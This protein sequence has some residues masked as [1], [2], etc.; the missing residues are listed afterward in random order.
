MK[1]LKL[2]TLLLFTLPALGQGV[3]RHNTALTRA[4]GTIAANVVPYAK[5][6]ICVAGTFCGTLQQVYSDIA[7]TQ[8][9]PQPVT[10][11]ASGNYSY[12]Y[13]PGCIDEQITSPNLGKITT[14][15]VCQFAAGTVT[16]LV[17]GTNISLS[18]TN[19]LGTVTIS[20]S[21]SGTCGPGVANYL[22]LSTVGGCAISLADF[23]VTNAGRFTFPASTDISG[24]ESSISTTGN[25]SLSAG[26]QFS[27][28]T[29]H[30]A[31]ISSGGGISISN[32]DNVTG[33][34]I[35]N[36]GTQPIILTSGAGENFL[37]TG[38]FLVDA[39]VSADF[40]GT[41]QFKLPVQAGYSTAAA[42]EIGYDSTNL[43]WH[44]QMAGGDYFMALF[45][46]GSPPTNGQCAS[47]NKVSNWW[48]L[49]GVSCGS[50]GSGFPIVIGSTT[51]AASSTNTS[52]SGLTLVAPA[53]GTPASVVLTN[54]TG[55]PLST[56]VTGTLQAAQEPAHTGDATNTAGSLAMTV[57][58]I[59]G[60]ALSGLATGLLK[61]TTTT[62][63]PSIATAGTDYV[64]PSGNITG[65]AGNLSGTPALPNGTTAT[66]QTFGDNTTKLATD[67]FVIANAG[68]GT[69]SGQTTGF[70][71]LAG[72]STS[73]TSTSPI[74]YGVT[75]ANT[76]TSSKPIAINA[77]GNGA[78][79]VE[80][81][82]PSGVASSDLI[83]PDSTAHRFRMN[84]NNGGAF[85]V[86]ELV[87]SGTIAVATGAI[88]SAT[89]ATTTT[90]VSGILST[91]A[92]AWNANGSLKAVT[93]Y[94][95]STSGGLTLSIYPTSGNLVVD[96]CNWTSGSITPG[97]VT[98]NYQV[99]R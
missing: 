37:V 54:A 52:L 97:A 45:P 92:V 24:S 40:S 44:V 21:G 29:T 28:A 96:N 7:L 89:C 20:S 39:S 69:V 22:L 65:T 78:A 41:S 71:G 15:N 51:I 42:G 5:I 53:L 88:S 23:G 64:V 76:V 55:L 25:I 73:I 85:S 67:A 11:D 61:N 68:S 95:P 4:S 59:N 2:A 9:L 14:Y 12:Y 93:G 94:V 1:I 75:T 43:N 8:V 6:N 16:Q 74:D 47:F 31:T 35:S 98:I 66:T 27:L 81:T 80:G 86:G 3:P 79:M 34:Q 77:S 91:D 72:S 84:N 18:P 99:T 26:N 46:S 10:A 58:A 83:Y 70:I 48:E 50:G 19:G 13:A 57:K 82:A 17:A 33:I 60:T 63:V 90:A 32:S 30:E 36:T 87:A 38:T 62:G 56:G 49:V